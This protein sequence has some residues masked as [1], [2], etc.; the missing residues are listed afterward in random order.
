[1]RGKEP[2][3]RLCAILRPYYEQGHTL[4]VAPWGDASMVVV[5]GAANAFVHTYAIY[6][7]PVLTVMKL[8]AQGMRCQ[9]QTTPS[10]RV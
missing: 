2:F 3:V 4:T 9:L 5:R 10:T 8:A 7:P 1:M 6:A